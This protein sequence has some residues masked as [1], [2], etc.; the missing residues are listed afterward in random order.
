MRMNRLRRLPVVA[1]GLATIASLTV[2]SAPPASA[3]TAWCDPYSVSYVTTGTSSR[4]LTHVSGYHL[5]PGGA[6]SI[7]RS[8]EFTTQLTAGVTLS[9]G[10]EVSA[11]SVIAS[12]KATYGVSLAASGSVTSKSAQSVT[13][14]IAASSRDR[15]YAAYAGRRYWK[16]S[17]TKYTC[18]GGVPVETARGTWR[19][20]QTHLEGIALCPASRYSTS[21]LAYKACIRTWS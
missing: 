4:R 1:A 21:S 15:Y 7:T 19:S 12:A 16:G 3:Y 6:L 17:W 8:A 18:R 20:F 2:A 10:A 11:S 13:S 5:P 14:S 9:A